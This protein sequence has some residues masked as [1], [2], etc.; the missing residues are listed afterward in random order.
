MNLDKID[1]TI[2]M[3]IFKEMEKYQNSVFFNL[4][5]KPKFHSFSLSNFDGMAN[6]KKKK[7]TKLLIINK[8]FFYH[9]SINN[10]KRKNKINKKQNIINI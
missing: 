10:I 1:Q 9:L 4:L 7:Q 8:R 3:H 6:L 2:C 5:K